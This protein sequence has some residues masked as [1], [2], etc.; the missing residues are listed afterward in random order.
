MQ[1]QLYLSILLI[2]LSA[3]CGADELSGT[4]KFEKSK[5]YFDAIKNVPAPKTTVV[6]IVNGKLSVAPGCSTTLK[7]QKYD[8]SE[9]FQSL[10]KEDVEEKSLLQFLGKNFTFTLPKNAYYSAGD[11]DD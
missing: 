6:Q 8:Y 4:W 3:H 11:T 2:S 10:L 5:E 7:K 1:K 9:A